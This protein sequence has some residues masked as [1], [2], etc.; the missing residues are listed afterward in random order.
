M[1]ATPES[2]KSSLGERSEEDGAG[3]DSAGTLAR[4]SEQE[5]VR[6]SIGHSYA[7]ARRAI[8]LVRAYRSEPRSTGRR[9]RECLAEV[10]LLRRT[11]RGLRAADRLSR[12][13]GMPGLRKVLRSD[14]N[15]TTRPSLASGWRTG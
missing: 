6:Q 10:A 8:E 1:E 5:D 14:S 15:S 2:A 7:A 11:I 12:G 3:P 13:A 4:A 9:E